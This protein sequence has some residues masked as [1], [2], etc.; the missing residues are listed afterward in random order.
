VRFAVRG[1]GQRRASPRSH[2][3]PRRDVLSRI[4]ISVA[5]VPAGSA[6]E[7][8]LALARLRVHL[9][10]RRASLAR[11]V[12]LNLFNSSRR[13]VLQTTNKQAPSGLQDAPIQSSLGT[14]ISARVSHS[15]ASGT[16]H[17]PDFQVL[18]S[19]DIEPTREVGTGLLN[20]VLAPVRLTSPHSGNG[21]PCSFASFRAKSVAGDLTLQ[22][23]QFRLLPRSKA[24]H[25]QQFTGRERSGYPDAPVDADN[26]L[27]TRC[28]NRVWYR[29]ERHVPA[30]APILNYP[31]GLHLW[32][33]RPR[34][35]EPHPSDLRHPNRADFSAKPSH[36]PLL[37]TLSDDAEPF[38]PAS[39]SPRRPLVW[40]L[41]IK[42]RS[43]R[44]GEIPQGLLLD[45]LRTRTQPVVLRAC[46][47][48]LPTLLQVTRRALTARAPMHMLFYSQIPDI[49]SMR[50][51]VS[52]HRLLSR[53]RKQPITMHTN[54]VATGAD[55]SGE[56][57]WH[58][59]PSRA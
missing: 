15:S 57:K 37:T 40:P 17:I 11:M 6:P 43:R 25:A 42:E 12:R 50:A 44:P 10:T 28:H 33:Q 23:P 14:N 48:E 20:P 36:V 54:T 29:G 53:C 9:P 19:D 8:G 38:A 55:I 1:P 13:L 32:W 52:Q 34:P 39:L 51:V 5:G 24:W 41:R 26:L 21:Q 45:H 30:S 22:M 7:D 58:S 2:G 35:A 59:K 47:R 31:V 3:V 56:V 49:P 4:H 18:D 16:C 27:V 46:S